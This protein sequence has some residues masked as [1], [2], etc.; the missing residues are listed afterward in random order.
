MSARAEPKR[1]TRWVDA[2]ILMVCQSSQ[3]L[4]IGGV[5]LFLPLIRRDL[6]LT[7]AQAGT[8]DAASSLIYA[9][10]QIPAGL[11]ADRLGPRRL[12]VLGLLG[13]DLLAFSFSLQHAYLGLVA[14]QALTGFFRALLFA[15]GMI[16]MGRLFAP[17]RR[18]TAMGLYVAGGVSS[19]VF[20]NL[21][22]PILVGPLGW[23]GNFA[24]FSGLGLVALAVF[25]RR[26]EPPSDEPVAQLRVPLKEA[27]QLLRFRAMWLIAAI[28]YVRLAVVFGVNV[29]LPTYVVVERHYSLAVAGALVALTAAIGA[30]ATVLGGFITDRL[31]RPMLVIGGS[32]AICAGD[33]VLLAHSHSLATLI[34]AVAI[35]ALFSQLYFGPLFAIPVQMFGLRNAGFIGG[36][37]NGFA[38]LGGFTFIYALGVIKDATGSFNAGFDAIAAACVLGVLATLA[39]ARTRARQP[40]AGGEHS[41]QPLVEGSQ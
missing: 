2:I 12:V 4:T 40:L 14:N 32:L 24:L 30:P 39:L 13:I 7:F 27:R 17:E 21:L 18:A 16:L 9:S 31:G 15:P 8:L 3:A 34:I 5:A 11:I 33:L 1:Q 41:R 28:Q 36:F 19:S 29:W 38:N 35:T 37:G 25:V 23:R 22:G 20:L 6:H 10:M 26:G